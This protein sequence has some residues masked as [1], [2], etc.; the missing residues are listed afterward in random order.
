[1]DRHRRRIELAVVALALV[2][3]AGSVGYYALGSYVD[4]CCVPDRR[5]GQHSGFREIDPFDAVGKTFTM[6]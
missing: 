1:M 2:L 3:V 4:R 5:H 6:V